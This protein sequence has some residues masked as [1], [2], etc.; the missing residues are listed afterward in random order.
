MA[1]P[2]RRADSVA[3]TGRDIPFRVSVAAAVRVIT[4]P[5]ENAADSETGWVRVTV[6]FGWAVTS[7]L[8]T[9]CG[10]RVLPFTVIAPRLTWNAARETWPPATVTVPL[11]SPVRPVTSLLR[12][13]LAL[14]ATLLSLTDGGLRDQVQSAPATAEQDH[15][16]RVARA[17]QLMAG[18]LGFRLRKDAGVTF[19]TLAVLADA[20]MRGLV[21]TAMTVPGV[22]ASGTTAQPFDA[23]EAA[24]WS[25]PA[26]ELGAI[27]TAF[28]EP[29]P[30][31][32]WDARRA[33][34][35]REALAAPDL[36]SDRADR[37]G[38]PDHFG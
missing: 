29:D 35:I 17:W 23:R 25:L 6:A 32:T 4:A 9:S 36:S 20:A 37:R 19:E 1:V 5:E 18:L 15:L 7:R 27:A 28:L 21:M 33:A 22:A 12:T 34:A 14:H 26:L 2:S 13:Y 8:L 3:V 10:W 30:D 31:F 24:E 11:T 38:Q 16:A